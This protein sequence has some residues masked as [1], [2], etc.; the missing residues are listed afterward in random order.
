[1]VWGLF[2]LSAENLEERGG[3]HRGLHSTGP[4][5]G[6]REILPVPHRTGGDGIQAAML[7][8]SL[9]RSEDKPACDLPV[10]HNWN[11]SLVRR[12]HAGRFSSLLEWHLTIRATEFYFSV[13]VSQPG[14][15]WLPV[16]LSEQMKLSTLWIAECIQGNLHQ[17]RELA[18]FLQQLEKHSGF[19]R[20]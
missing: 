5:K 11:D 2:L 1:M 18:S 10:K 4:W 6:Q 13:S 16:L 14:P 7:V 17:K 3:K 15:A 19:S 8:E 9:H 12:A 20:H